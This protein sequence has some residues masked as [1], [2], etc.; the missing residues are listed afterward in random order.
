MRKVK[1]F[2]FTYYFKNGTSIVDDGIVL[3]VPTEDN[4]LRFT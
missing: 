2:K 1:G 3:K 4:D